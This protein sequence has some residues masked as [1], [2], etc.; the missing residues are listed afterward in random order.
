M[1]LT[2]PVD[3]PIVATAGVPEDHTPPPIVS[4]NVMRPPTGTLVGPDIVPVGV[5][6]LTETVRVAY[7]VPHGPVVVN[8]IVVEPRAIPVTTPL[9]DPIIAIPGPA[10]LHVPVS[11]VLSVRVIVE[12]IQTM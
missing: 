9:A 7:T 12:P 10:L 2:F 1:P 8:V 11:P 5:V 6:P 4:D 3:D